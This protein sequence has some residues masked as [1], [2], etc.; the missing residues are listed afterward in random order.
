MPDAPLDPVEVGAEFEAVRVVTAP[1]A[2]SGRPAPPESPPEP[3]AVGAEFDSV[4]GGK[5][6]RLEKASTRT[7]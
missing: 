3:V 2:G 7:A 6:V 4:R 5:Y 1:A